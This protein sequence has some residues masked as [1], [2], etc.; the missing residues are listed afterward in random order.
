MAD[1]NLLRM[2]RIITQDVNKM[3]LSLFEMYAC[4]QPLLHAQFLPQQMSF[5][6]NPIARYSNYRKH[7]R[8]HSFRI[9][10]FYRYPWRLRKI[11][12]ANQPKWIGILFALVRPLMPAKMRQ[13]ISLYGRNYEGMAEEFGADHVPV[14]LGGE[15]VL[16]RTQQAVDALNLVAVGYPHLAGEVAEMVAEVVARDGDGTTS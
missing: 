7:V 10:S 8:T 13:R 14:H 11:A 1:V 3:A 5:V 16:N 15:V 4:P 9:V 6:L 2:N 12:V